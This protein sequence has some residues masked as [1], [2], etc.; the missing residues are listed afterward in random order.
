MS[1]TLD[2]YLHRCLAGRLLQDEHGQMAFY[3]AESWL[4]NSEAVPL[5]H[6]LPLRKER[7]N[8]NQCRGYVQEVSP[9]RHELHAANGKLLGYYNPHLDQT[10]TV[11]GR[12]LGHGNLLASML[13]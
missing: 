4:D 6:S 2:V 7:F 8:R 13:N 5:S 11:S 10:F 3:Y 9:S 1:R 12:V